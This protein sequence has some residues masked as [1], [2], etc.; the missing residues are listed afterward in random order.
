[1]CCISQKYIQTN[2][3]IVN[4]FNLQNKFFN[5]RG[6]AQYQPVYIQT[7]T[8]LAQKFVCASNLTKYHVFFLCL[9]IEHTS[10]W[11]FF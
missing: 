7:T 4:S 6:V 1:M 2:N 5:N 3:K 10:V 11:W 8:P 9:S